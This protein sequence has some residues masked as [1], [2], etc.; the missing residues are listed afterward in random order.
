[1]QSVSTVGTDWQAMHRND[2]LKLLASLEFPN[3]SKEEKEDLLERW[4]QMD[5]MDQQFRSLS[6]GCKERLAEGKEP[7]PE[8]S[9]EMFQLDFI[10]EHSAYINS[11]IAGL[12]ANAGQGDV[13]IEGEVEE[14]QACQI[15]SYKSVEFDGWDI[16]KVC[17]WQDVGKL[18]DDEFCT[19]NH[20]RPFVARARFKKYGSMYPVETSIEHKRWRNAYA[21]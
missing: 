3:Q 8:C 4:P 7:T 13:Q 18:A 2:A 6:Q 5:D 15:C 14:M 9:L 11:W 12:M 1:M 17:L 16:C 20:S 10:E 21:K 19:L